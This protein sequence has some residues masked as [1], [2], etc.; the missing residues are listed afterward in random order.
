L[1]AADCMRAA[2]DCGSIKLVAHFVEVLVW[3]RDASRPHF[4]LAVASAIM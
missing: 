2:H 3:D 1:R 4:P